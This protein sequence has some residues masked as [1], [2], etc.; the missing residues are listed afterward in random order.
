MNITVLGGGM[1]GSAIA[2]DLSQE[3][4]FAVTVAENDPAALLRYA[5]LGIATVEAD[6]SDAAQLGDV[7]AHADLVIGAVPGFMGYITLRRVIEAGKNIV[8]ISFFPEDPFSLD[9]LAKERGVTAVMDCGLAPGL[10]NMLMGRMNA[11]LDRVA[12]AA[13]LEVL[14]LSYDTL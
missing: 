10:G 13:W 14:G 7:I 3:A 4:S 5:S 6:L 2:R 12:N 9:A 8:D 11:D 1:V